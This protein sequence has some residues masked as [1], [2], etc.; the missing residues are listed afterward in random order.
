MQ[1]GAMAII[2][3]LAISL[4]IGIYSAMRQDTATDYVARTFAVI[5]IK[6][7]DYFLAARAIGSPAPRRWS[8]MS[9]PI[10]WLRSSSYSPSTSGE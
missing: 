10:S 2:I 3:G 1:L 5:G 8:G 4:P 7:N 6:E 9:C